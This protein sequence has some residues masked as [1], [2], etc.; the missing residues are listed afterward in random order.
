MTTVKIT[1]NVDKICQRLETNVTGLAEILNVTPATVWNWKKGK[2]NPS[3]EHLEKL[4]KE[5]GFEKLSD[6]I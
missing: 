1:M 2:T 6:F 3:L 5:T 4:S